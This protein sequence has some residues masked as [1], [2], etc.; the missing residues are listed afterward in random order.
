MNDFY[1]PEYSSFV[2]ED[3]PDNHHNNLIGSFKENKNKET[4]Q[5]INNQFYIEN[6]A[7]SIVLLFI[8]IIFDLYA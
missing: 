4:H 3:T 6:W 5:I 2:D 7:I 8:I 1:F